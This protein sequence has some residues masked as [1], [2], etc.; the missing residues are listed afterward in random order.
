[1]EVRGILRTSYGQAICSLAL[2]LYLWPER[3]RID[4]PEPRQSWAQ[5]HT[6]YKRHARLAAVPCW[7]VF[8]RLCTNPYQATRHWP[9]LTAC[10]V[11]NM[12]FSQVYPSARDESRETTRNDR[13]IIR[14]C[15]GRSELTASD[16]EMD[17]YLSYFLQKNRETTSGIAQ[18][19]GREQ[20]CLR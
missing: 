17:A 20:D 4:W 19:Q 15:S 11:S 13:Q 5:C 3:A 10:M 8:W 16:L 2:C 7:G 12:V 9:D 14:Y 18:H 1:M 6:W